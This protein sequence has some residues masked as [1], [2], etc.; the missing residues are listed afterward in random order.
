MKDNM[1]ESPNAPEVQNHENPL[2]TAPISRLMLSFGLPGVISLLVTSLY[3]I[4]DQIFIG[5]GVGYLGNAATN[6]LFPM[7]TITFA[8]ALLIGSGGAAFFALKLGAGDLES[9]QKS[10]DNTLLMLLVLGIVIP[11]GGFIFLE[12]LARLFGAT[13]NILPY[14]LDYGG[15]I[16]LGMPFVVMATGM[17]ALIRADGSPTVAMLSMI[18]GAV[19]NTIL[20]PIFIFAFGWGVRGAAF[21][22]V[23]GQALTFLI[24]LFW[25]GRFRNIRIRISRIRL[26]IPTARM[27]TA[28]G[29]SSFITQITASLTM[30]VANN[31]LVKYGRQSIY[32]AD[33]PMA[34][35]G[36]TMKIFMIMNSF[37]VGMAVGSQP[38]IGFNY[39]ARQFDRVKK[40]YVTATAIATGIG[41]IAFLIFQFA[42][43][44]IINLFGSEEALYNEFAR[45]C[46]RIFLMLTPLTGFQIVSSIFFQAIG[47]PLKATI[48][49]LSK[50]VLSQAPLMLLLPVFLGVNGVLWAGPLSDVIGFS[51]IFMLIAFELKTTREY[52]VSMV[53]NNRVIGGR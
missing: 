8:F 38:I 11:L 10:A 9:A 43:Q 29:T 21:A 3:N 35:F 45:K 37:I 23:I 46:L 50:Q 28:L 18:A 22:T 40:T 31:M 39:G 42:P 26:H 12:P 36:I 27:I 13:D 33:I 19:T 14:A 44:A 20:D 25:M 30:F 15:I 4:V 5:R 17:N 32:G 48:A 2:G 16:M 49:T 34:V 7:V 53:G 24:S 47:K 41:V 1:P 51:V 6:V 52:D